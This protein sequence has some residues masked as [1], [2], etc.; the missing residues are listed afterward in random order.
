MYS[1]VSSIVGFNAMKSFKQSSR[2][3]QKLIYALF[4]SYAAYLSSNSPHK[5]PSVY[6]SYKAKQELKKLYMKATKEIRQ[7]N[8]LQALKCEVKATLYEV[9]EMDISTD[10]KV[11]I[12]VDDMMLHLRNFIS[13]LAVELGSAETFSLALKLC[14]NQRAIKFTEFIIDYYIDNEIPMTDKTVKMI[15]EQHHDK[16]IYACLRNKKCCIC[17]STKDIH[18]EHYIPVSRTHGTYDKDDGTGVYWSLC[19]KCH[20]NKHKVGEAEY[21]KLTGRKGIRL[22]EEQ[23]VELT[24]VYKHIFKGKR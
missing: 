12:I 17:G 9:I 22:T 10:S 24:E 6:W 21:T 15:E 18:F 4:Q 2:Q 23:V 13:D 8:A 1:V 3:N 7:D 14:D 16:L 19:P 11:K 5:L 20:D